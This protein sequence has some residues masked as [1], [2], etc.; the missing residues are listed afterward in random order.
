MRF[1]KALSLMTV[2]A[3]ICGSLVGCSSSKDSSGGSASGDVTVDIFQ[4]KVETQE[5]LQAAAKKYE[6]SHDGVKINIETI[7]GGNDYGAGLR[8]KFQSGQEPTI[9]NIG[10]PQDVED[11]ASKLEDLSDE[12]WVNQAFEGTLGSVTTDDG[13]FGMP[14][15][16]EGYGFIYNKQ[17]F[18]KAGINPEE[19]TT[20]A[21]LEE[22]VETLDSKKSELGIE[23]VFAF[24]GKEKWVTGLHLLNVALGNEFASGK[25]SL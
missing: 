24:P 23:A 11:W 18:E 9:F 12:P 7:G 20:F 13:I 6:E 17:I 16:Q 21:K 4:F 5:A 19:I 8:T 22:A 15:A 1:K 10:G 3:L 25:A 14:F 2:T